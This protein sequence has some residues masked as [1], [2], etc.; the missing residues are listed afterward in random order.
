MGFVPAARHVLGADFADGLLI[1]F[2][3]LSILVAA[4]FI[5]FQRDPKRLLAYHNV[6]HLGIITLGFGLGPLGTFAAVFHTLNDSVCKSLAFFTVGRL[7]QEVGSHD[8]HTLS[9]AL[10]ADR[11]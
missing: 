9:N 11:L 10:R 1:F 5:V 8:M 7:G 4:A 2:G 3:T 6:E